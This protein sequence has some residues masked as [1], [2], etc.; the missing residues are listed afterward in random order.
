MANDIQKLYNLPEISFIEGIT[1]EGILNE[2]V[3]D[4]EAKYEE[5]T[6]R[7]IRL[8]PGDKEHIHLRV[9]AGQYYQMYRQLDYAAKMNLLKYSK[10]DFLKHLG[11][12]KKTFI[13]EPR[14]AVVKVRFTLSEARKDVIYIPEGTRVTAGDGVYFATDDYAEVA[15]GETYADV[16]CTCETAGDIGNNYQP[17]T[18]EI[19]V[20]PVPY[21]KSVVNV[22]KSDGG[23]GEESEESFRE[24]IFL[25]PSSY[26]V[27]G[28]ADAYEYWVKQYNSA[29]I[30]DVK[31][32]EPVEAVV[33]IRILLQGGA[34]PSE[35]FCSGCL[36]YLKDNP[37]IPLTDN[38]YV[39]PPD[40]VGYDLK[41]TYY[42]SRSDI[43]N[44]KSIQDS[45]EAAKDT[46]L[47]WQRT[48]IGRDL[49]PDALIEF[50]RA[51]GGKRCVI[52][53][54]VFTVI[55]ET[56]VAQEVNVEFVYGGIED[57]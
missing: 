46:Y 15:A 20:D 10:G 6:K 13:Q 32:Y 47:N 7:K 23:S 53:S 35:T 12:F 4:Y 26:S 42:I 19:I 2:M 25:A 31:I 51:A 55:P 41:A 27:A 28:P 38:N 52:E 1:Y 40:V 9:L 11:A 36:Q 3:A 45:I 54:P 33:D 37:I 39:L 14:A 21:V 57:D 17:G 8:R 49:N 29:A 56:S 50:V 48:K 30:E 44:V 22:T 34:L 24:R 43:N 16:T 5:D 18:I